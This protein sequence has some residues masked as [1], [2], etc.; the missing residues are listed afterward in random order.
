METL[1]VLLIASQTIQAAYLTFAHWER[2][3]GIVGDF[4]NVEDRITLIEENVAEV[5]KDHKSIRFATGL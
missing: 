4:D 3:Q 2:K 5:Q 1:I